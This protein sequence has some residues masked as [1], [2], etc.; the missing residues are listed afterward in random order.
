MSVKAAVKPSGLTS[1][2]GAVNS[3]RKSFTGG[4]FNGEF[5]VP[6]DGLFHPDRDITLRR[7]L[8]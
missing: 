4:G 7:T 6:R 2:K 1:P 3:R 5:L 8:K